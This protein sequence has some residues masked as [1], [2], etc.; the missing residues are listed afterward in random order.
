MKLNVS[1][2]RWILLN[3][4][5][6]AGLY[7]GKQYAVIEPK[8]P[9]HQVKLDRLLGSIT[10]PSI[11]EWNKLSRELKP[12]LKATERRHYEYAVRKLAGMSNARLAALNNKQRIEL[13]DGLLQDVIGRDPETFEQNRQTVSVYG[14]Q[15]KI[16]LFGIKLPD[17]F[18]KQE[19]ARCD[20]FCHRL[21][22]VPRLKEDLENWFELDFWQQRELAEN[23]LKAFNETYHTQICCRFFNEKE[24]YEAKAAQKTEQIHKTPQMTYTDGK[25]IFINKEKLAG[26]NN[27]SVPALLFHEALQIAR[28]QEDWAN[29][30]LIDK[31]FEKKF[32]YLALE[33]NDLY[34]MNPMETHA[35]QMDES[36]VCFLLEKMQIKLMQ[37]ECPHQSDHLLCPTETFSPQSYEPPKK[38]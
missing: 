14:D 32:D 34:A 6:M 12:K 22:S 10:F 30:P 15:L 27:L 20:Q 25:T 16:L 17:E 2:Y 3:C 33:G 37:N 26:Y 21:Q 5:I 28:R 19:Q 36:V 7:K 29:F 35:Y 18:L 11:E 1:E 31:L 13:L 8:F 23:V 9:K 24:W 4:N 38:P